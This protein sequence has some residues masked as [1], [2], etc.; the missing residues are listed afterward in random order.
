[1]KLITH[2]NYWLGVGFGLGLFGAFVWRQEIAAWF[3]ARLRG[4][5]DWFPA[6]FCPKCDQRLQR[7]PR[8][9]E[10]VCP[11]CG[12]TLSLNVFGFP[13]VVEVGAR[14]HYRLG[15]RTELERKS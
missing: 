15:I 8:F 5:G 2:L 6:Y 7:Q 11:L 1:M 4:H 14:W 12:A 9:G 10:N 13:L 3:C